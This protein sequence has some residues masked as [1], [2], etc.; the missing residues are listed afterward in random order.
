MITIRRANGD[1]TIIKLSGNRRKPYAIRKVIG[2]REDGGR[3]IK[4]VSYHKTYREAEQALAAY[5]ANP[6]YISKRTLKDVYEEWYRQKEPSVSDSTLKNYRVCMNHLEPLQNMKIR[7]IDRPTLQKFYNELDVSQNTLKLVIQTLNM[8]FDYA[9]KLGILPTTALNLNQTINL[10][11]KGQKRA[12]KTRTAINKA[13]IEMLWQ[14]T[15]NK[16]VKM[17]LVYIYTGLR[18]SELRELKPENWHENYIEITHSKTKSGI[19]IVPICDKIRP[20]LPIEPVPSRTAF[21]YDFKK[22][23]PNN[24]IHETRHT[25]ISMLTEAKVDP[26]VIKAIVG[27]RAND[28]TQFYTHISLDVMMEAV[29]RL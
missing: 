28:V 1:G 14:N 20:L 6:Y 27:H 18:F 7:D 16:H 9:V 22:W 17:I 23:L 19:R 21:E 2:W 26:R 29:N 5:N 12:Q 11:T 4:Y 15:D 3:I 24:L 8:I 25:F 13:D 10:P